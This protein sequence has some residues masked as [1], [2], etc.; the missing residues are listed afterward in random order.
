MSTGRDLPRIRVSQDARC[1]ISRWRAPVRGSRRLASCILKNVLEPD[2]VHVL[3]A[4]Y[5][6]AYA[7]YHRD[8]LH[9]DARMWGTDE[10]W[11][12]SGSPGI[13]RSPASTPIQP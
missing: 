1:L 13:Q 11:S 8:I 3:R 9:A 7:A 10:T 5:E 2:H 12:R 4:D 6:K